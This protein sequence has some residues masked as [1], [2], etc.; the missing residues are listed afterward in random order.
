M[1]KKWRVTKLIDNATITTFMAEMRKNMETLSASVADFQTG[2]KTNYCIPEPLKVPDIQASDISSD[3]DQVD[4][5]E[6]IIYNYG[7]ITC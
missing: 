4:D 5:F 6:K 7:P 3:E 1:T 2:K